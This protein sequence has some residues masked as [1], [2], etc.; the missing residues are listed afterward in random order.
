MVH[1]LTDPSDH[2]LSMSMLKEDEKEK[3][4]TLVECYMKQYDVSQQE[5]AKAVDDFIEEDWMI[6]NEELLNPPPNVPIQLLMVL[7]HFAKNMDTLY[8]DYDGYT[9]CDTNT[10]DMITALI[11]TL[12]VIS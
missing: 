3:K 11:V 10:K 8:K 6:M 2:N 12:M 4:A 5:A 7:L 1:Y 9:H